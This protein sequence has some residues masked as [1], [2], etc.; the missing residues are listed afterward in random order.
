MRRTWWA[1]LAWLAGCALPLDNL[2]EPC[3]LTC[4]PGLSCVEGVCVSPVERCGIATCS[5]EL[6][7][8]PGAYCRD[9]A[10]VQ[11][12]GGGPPCE[13]GTR[14]VADACVGPVHVDLG[15]KMG[16]AAWPDGRVS[17]W[18]QN[19]LMTEADDLAGIAEPRWVG[20]VEDAVEV[21]VGYEFACARSAEGVV[22]CWGSNATGQ[23]AT[24]LQ[25]VP[26][27]SSAKEISLGRRA[28]RGALVV[29]HA[30][31]CVLSEGGQPMC[32]GDDADGQLRYP[33]DRPFTALVVGPQAA[34]G[35]SPL[36]NLCWGRGVEGGQL[37]DLPDARSLAMGNSICVLD[38]AG[39]ARCSYAGFGVPYG[40]SWDGP[41]RQLAAGANAACVVTTAGSTECDGLWWLGARRYTELRP[42]DEGP[43]D[44]RLL[45][46]EGLLCRHRPNGKLTCAEASARGHLGQLPRTSGWR[47]HEDLVGMEAEGNR[48]CGIRAD[49]VVCAGLPW[50]TEGG[51]PCGS[52][53]GVL[54]CDGH[55]DERAP[56]FLPVGVG[57]A[58]SLDL[59]REH[60][61]A[62]VDGGAAVACWGDN[63]AGQ[64]A[65]DVSAKLYRGRVAALTGGPWRAVATADRGSCALSDAGEVFCW[66][67]GLTGAV[68]RGVVEVPIPPVVQLAASGEHAVAVDVTGRAWAWGQNAFGEVDPQAGAPVFVRADSPRIG[69]EGVVEAAPGMD[70][71]CAR[72]A[73]GQVL[74]WG[75]NQDGELGDGSV[76]A[77]KGPTAVALPAPAIHV[78]AGARWTC[79]VGTVDTRCWGQ[80]TAGAFLGPDGP[81]RYGR[82]FPHSQPAPVRV[83]G[84]PSL[85]RLSLGVSH[86]CGLT[87]D[88]RS[89]C[90]GSDYHGEV[91][92]V[93][94]GRPTWQTI[95]A[96]DDP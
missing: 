90:W 88:G 32:W 96:P 69:V 89:G 81:A 59:G 12:C 27:S 49:D 26:R 6:P 20:G 36:G 73:D 19:D 54:V 22:S 40:G 10:C 1:L 39:A 13:V 57:P 55:Q 70:H 18:G 2:C 71:T 50:A 42:P 67:E 9:G 86:A 47:S 30:S 92:A 53:G 60:G 93:P 65:P 48:T 84:L 94:P 11:G 56:G 44:E 78:A 83:H 85:A 29:G 63:S 17:C 15:H 3:T 46:D 7:C 75:R 23:L 95:P 91:S 58:L 28:E 77:P 31:A 41:V 62:V 45:V 24:S 76:G 8:D 82:A 21:G 80:E 61:C 79:A 66:G 34:C 35:L 14:C 68:P 87:A 38:R 51:R 4:G 64:A 25:S 52:I 16:C 37:E 43:G 5:L 74:C 72:R 33:R